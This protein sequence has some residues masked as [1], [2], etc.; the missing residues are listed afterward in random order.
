MA[1]FAQNA[2]QQA[3]YR[4]LHN[5]RVGAEDTLQPHW[6][7]PLDR[8]QL[9]P[10]VL[11]V[12]DT[13][14]LNYIGLRGNARG[15]GP[16][17]KRN[18]RTRGLWVHVAIAFTQGRWPLGVSGLETWARPEQE[19]E[20]EKESRRWLR[21]L[22]QGREPGWGSPQTRVIM[23]GDRESDI[24]ELFR[25]QREHEGDVGLLV[26]AHRERQRRVKVWSPALRSLIMRD[27]EA[28]PDH[29]KPVLTEM[30]GA[31]RLAGREAGAAAAVSDHGVAHRG[32][33]AAAAA[34]PGGGGRGGGVGGAGRGDVDPAG[35]G[36][37]AGVA[38]G[39]K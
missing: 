37:A 14:T 29:L 7:A 12:Q 8:C 21:G 25:R 16:L 35:G 30:Q 24:Y 31:H 39:L 32:G 23:V 22:E 18:D 15:L 4:F 28:H 20:A 11:L 19:P 34:G 6:E 5:G 26:R 10:T 13:T 27:L 2:A 33:G 3:A 36:A 38:A 17:K 1:V 9:E